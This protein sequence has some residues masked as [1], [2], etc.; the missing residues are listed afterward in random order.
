[1]LEKDIKY[2]VIIIGGSYAGLSAGTILGRSLRKVLIIDGKSPRNKPTP[3][4]HSFLWIHN[5]VL[6]V[7]CS[8]RFHLVQHQPFQYMRMVKS[9]QQ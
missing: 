2:D 3:F 9:L 4:S 6:W 7:S 1:M 8:L 5:C